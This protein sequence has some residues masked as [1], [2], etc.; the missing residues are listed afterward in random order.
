MT[1]TSVGRIKRYTF[2]SYLA[3]ELNRRQAVKDKKAFIAFADKTNGI[4]WLEVNL[5][6]D[7]TFVVHSSHGDLT[8][9]AEGYVLHDKSTYADHELENITRFDIGE[10]KKHY[11]VASIDTDRDILDLG[12]WYRAGK[13]I[14]YE[15]P[16]Q[17]WRDEAKRLDLESR[18]VMR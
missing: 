9:T 16:V 17:S 8:V 5:E 15:E 10:Y 11:N 18:E 13:F 7:P 4:Y 14:R 3:F 2:E 6:P 12:Y 1:N